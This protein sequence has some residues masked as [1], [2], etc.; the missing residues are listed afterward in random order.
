MTETFTITVWSAGASAVTMALFGVDHY[1]ML[2]GFVGAIMAL[3]V[4]D[5][6]L[7]VRRAVLSVV[8]STLAGAAIGVAAT[9]LFESASRGALFVSAAVGGAGAQSIIAALLRA[10]IA[11]IERIGGRDGNA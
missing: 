10:A 2:Y 7:G 3:P 4:S 8:L 5:Q 1:A 6:R 9:E 11:R